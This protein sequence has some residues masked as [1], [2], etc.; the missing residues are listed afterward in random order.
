M[1]GARESARGSAPAA[2]CAA[3]RESMFA[4]AR[5][6]GVPSSVPRD[7]C[8]R[9][10]DSRAESSR[11][12]VCRGVRRRDRIVHA[13]RD[14]E[15]RTRPSCRARPQRAATFAPP[16][17]FLAPPVAPG[18][19]GVIDLSKDDDD[20]S[21]RSA[22]IARSLKWCP[23]PMDLSYCQSVEIAICLDI[24]R[25]AARS[26][27]THDTRHQL[28]VRAGR[29]RRLR[30]GATACHCLFPTGRRRGPAPRPGAVRTHRK[31]TGILA[32]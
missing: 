17:S 8:S 15:A 3:T 11:R 4:R 27:R 31:T 14:T 21:G 12:L 9:S 2:T 29:A 26:A 24:I 22:Q 25:L 30:C 20:R 10:R 16:P 32:D 6:L 23:P 19:R 7:A 28:A 18:Q 13:E 5:L 1:R